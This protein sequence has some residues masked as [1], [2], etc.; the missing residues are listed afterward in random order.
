MNRNINFDQL[1]DRYLFKEIEVRAEAYLKQHPDQR[2][3]RMG[4]G[5]VTRPLPAAI[6]DAMH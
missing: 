4:I 2:L 1:P 6:T 3:L 5:D